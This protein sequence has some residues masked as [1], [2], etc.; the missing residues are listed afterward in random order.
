MSSALQSEPRL[1]GLLETTPSGTPGDLTVLGL[2]I[3]ARNHSL[4]GVRKNVPELASMGV[5]GSHVALIEAFAAITAMVAYRAN[6]IPRAL[7][8]NYLES[9]GLTRLD[10]TPALAEVY[11][12]GADGRDVIWVEGA[13]V[14]SGF[15]EYTVAK[16]TVVPAGARNYG[17]I[18]LICNRRGTVGNLHANHA[19]WAS[20]QPYGIK[21]IRNPNPVQGGAPAETDDEF[22]ERATKIAGARSLAAQQG[23]LEAYAL[24]TS[25]VERVL[26]LEHTI[27]RNATRWNNFSYNESNWNGGVYSQTREGAI[28]CV[29]RPYGGGF[30]N[31][32]LASRVGGAL[33]YV[34][35]S[36]S[37]LW[38]ASA[39]EVMLDVAL[40]VQSDR[41]LP[42]SVLI[43]RVEA[44]VRDFLSG[45]NWPWGQDFSLAELATVASK[46]VGVRAVPFANVTLA[47]PNVG[48]YTAVVE[49]S[50]TT[51]ITAVVPSVLFIAKAVIVTVIP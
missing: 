10:A 13:K 15:A 11:V 37:V 40:Q 30:L 5:D 17:P 19:G 44:A 4:E 3:A 7:L 45:S 6:Q 1:D 14:T 21:N 35:P 9:L 2:A 32:E 50:K 38:V 34:R 26:V 46:V 22:I 43:T 51:R 36:G 8:V 25:G 28:T 42:D 33:E 23:T 48:A 12:D 16:G 24:R 27:F 20:V 47:S 31:L 49:D 29:V 39:E 18:P 41:T